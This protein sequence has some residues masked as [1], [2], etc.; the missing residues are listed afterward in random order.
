V[1]RPRG[2]AYVSVLPPAYHWMAVLDMVAL[3]VRLPRPAAIRESLD[4][5]GLGGDLARPVGT[6]SSDALARLQVAFLLVTLPV[7]AVIDGPISAPIQLL[8]AAGVTV[9][10]A[11]RAATPVESFAT[12][13]VMLAD[14]VARGTMR[15]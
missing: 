12:R 9:M 1:E 8:P 7:L 2:V 5:V 6:L 15:V 13:V 11:A 4:R 3:M 14:G 10:L